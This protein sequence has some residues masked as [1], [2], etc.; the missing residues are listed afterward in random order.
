MCA[1]PDY[2][3]HPVYS[4]HKQTKLDLE[5]S[6]DAKINIFACLFYQHQLDRIWNF[7]YLSSSVQNLVPGQSTIHTHCGTLL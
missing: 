5:E 2:S 4:T 3:H 7:L 1:R 6:C